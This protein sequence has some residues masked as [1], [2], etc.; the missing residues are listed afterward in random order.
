VV[1]EGL[2]RHDAA[3]WV[4]QQVPKLRYLRDDAWNLLPQ[5]ATALLVRWDLHMDYK[6]CH[7]RC[8]PTS[9]FAGSL[10][11]TVCEDG[12]E[13]LLRGV[14]SAGWPVQLD[15]AEVKFVGTA[16]SPT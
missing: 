7:Q 16:D 8:L 5:R 15:I 1:V 6:C 10:I 2:V 12:A 13:A 3:T 14:P 4:E 9:F 11:E